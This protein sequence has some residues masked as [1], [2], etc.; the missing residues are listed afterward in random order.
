MK[1]RRGAAVAGGLL[2][3]TGLGS[4]AS[5]LGAQGGSALGRA[6]ETRAKPDGSADDRRLAP[7]RSVLHTLV[8]TWRFEVRFA[9]NFDGPPD[10][11]GTRSIKPLFDT[12]HLAWSETLDHSDLL[13]QGVIGFDPTSGR[14]F[15]SAIYSGDGAP[16]FMAG[17][18]DAAEPLVTFRPIALAPDSGAPASAPSRAGAFTLS[19]FDGNHFTVAALDREWRATFARQP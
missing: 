15:S 14:F 9:G 13:G 4:G 1:T 8:G 10:A 11:S 18:L 7:A 17:T 3:L 5:Q 2:V 19:M 6:H 12:L 16:E